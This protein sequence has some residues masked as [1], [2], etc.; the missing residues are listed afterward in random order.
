MAKINCLGSIS[1]S[2]TVKRK[3]KQVPT[4]ANAT[5]AATNVNTEEVGVSARGSFM[6]NLFVCRGR[7]HMGE[8]NIYAKG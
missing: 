5:Y 2:S 3:G 1:H 4:L 7:Y 8:N 6:K